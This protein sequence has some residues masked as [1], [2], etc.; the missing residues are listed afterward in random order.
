MQFQGTPFEDYVLDEFIK[1]QLLFDDSYKY[2]KVSQI[3]GIPETPKISSN[4]KSLFHKSS[5]LMKHLTELLSELSTVQGITLSKEFMNNITKFYALNKTEF[6]SFTIESLVSSY[7]DFLTKKKVQ[8]INPQYYIQSIQLIDLMLLCKSS[9][10]EK[11]TLLNLRSALLNCSY[12]Q[13]PTISDKK[14]RSAIC[15]AFN[16]S[17]EELFER[18]S[19]LSKLVSKNQV[20]EFFKSGNVLSNTYSESDFEQPEYYKNWLV[21]SRSLEE[22]MISLFTDPALPSSNV[23][24]T[25]VPNQINDTM[26]VLTTISLNS[27]SAFFQGLI[28]CMQLWQINPFYIQSKFVEASVEMSKSTNSNKINPELVEKAFNLSYL[29]M[30]FQVQ[31]LEW[32]LE[33]KRASLSLSM[34]IYNESK[35]SIK[36]YFSM[37]FQDQEAFTVV[38]S[39]LKLL[40]LNL[41]NVKLEIRDELAKT[42]DQ[43]LSAHKAKTG[44]LDSDKMV[45]LPIMVKF[46]TLVSRDVNLLFNWKTANKDLNLSFQIFELGSKILMTPTLEYIKRFIS[47]VKRGGFSLV[48]DKDSRSNF[49]SFID[50]VNNLKA[51]TNFKYDFQN[52]IY[53]DFYKIVQSWDSDMINK[54]KVI[55]ANDDLTRL[56]GCSYSASIQ[57]LILLLEGYIKLLNSFQWRDQSQ[58]S[59]LSILLY[60]NIVHSI[61]Y[62]HHSMMQKMDQMNRSKDSK[63]NV[64]SF[65]CLNNIYKLLEFLGNLEKDENIMAISQYVVT[66]G[67]NRSDGQKSKNKYISLLIKNAENIEDNR[68]NPIDVKVRLSGLINSETRVISKDY[69]PDWYEEFNT[70]ITTKSARANGIIKIELIDTTTGGTYKTV[71]YNVKLNSES[72]F[73]NQNEKIPLKPKS[74]SLNICV[75]VEFEKNDPLFYVLNCKSEIENSVKRSINFFIETYL[76]DI[77]SV[78]SLSYLQKSIKESPIRSE[79]DYKR[80]QD[81]LIDNLIG[82]FQVKILPQAYNNLETKLFD[83]LVVEFWVKILSIAENLLLPRLSVIRYMITNKLS[84]NKSKNPITD[85]SLAS[86]PGGNLSRVTN[87]H[88][89]HETTREE[90]IR[91]VEWCFKFRAMLDIPDMIL[92][93][94]LETPFKEFNEMKELFQKPLSNLWQLYYADWRYLSHHMIFRLSKGTSYDRSGWA[95]AS[96]RKTLVLRI[97]LAKNREQLVKVK[98]ALE[99]EQRFERVVKTEIEVMYLQQFL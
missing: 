56:D 73:K 79:N 90:L 29:A 13:L 26:S 15:S 96:R 95:N 80:L 19:V 50:L 41:K 8:T 62:Y 72:L 9:S 51:R 75:T 22:D 70:H 44:I 85:S 45:R 21:K 99:A 69:N 64:D 58:L 47:D 81:P 46:L 34:K 23:K 71:N 24:S 40:K 49:G 38:L 63:M 36:P 33:E 20:V 55:L 67:R 10:S 86:S 4:S 65:V 89:I 48:S 16:I 25:I 1:V 83:S 37:F 82:N 14:Q 91:V 88:Q 7:Q 66:S 2:V 76:T 35:D 52:E 18:I 92:Q 12:L 59:E 87:H 61:K 98:A 32:P 94:G 17:E 84:K 3:S 60:Q 11:S 93:D 57:N 39:F 6:R 5:A 27:S 28:K 42:I 78:F 54:T 74:G 77:K 68:G 53:E 97:L 30:P 31:F 43:R